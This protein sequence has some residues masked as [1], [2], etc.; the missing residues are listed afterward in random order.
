MAIQGTAAAGAALPSPSRVSDVLVL[1]YRICRSKTHK[2]LKRTFFNGQNVH[3]FEEVLFFLYFH[4]AEEK[5]ETK[6]GKQS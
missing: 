4:V 6:S 3:I 5:E 1:S 2:R